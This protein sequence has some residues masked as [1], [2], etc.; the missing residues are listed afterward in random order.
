MAACHP[1][2]PKNKQLMKATLLRKI[3]SREAVVG[4]VGLDA[5]EKRLSQWAL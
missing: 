3:Q 5:E 2:I 1:K 4:I